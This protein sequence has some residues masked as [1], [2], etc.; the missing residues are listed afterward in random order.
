MK[1]DLNIVKELINHGANV[2]FLNKDGWSSLHLAA[3]EG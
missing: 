1:G 2:N 3:K